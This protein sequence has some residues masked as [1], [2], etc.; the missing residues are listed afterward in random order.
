MIEGRCLRHA[1]IRL[2]LRRVGL[3]LLVAI[4]VPY[5]SLH[6]AIADVRPFVAIVFWIEAITVQGEALLPNVEGPCVLLLKMPIEAIG[7]DIISTGWAL[8]DSDWPHSRQS[9][10]GTSNRHCAWF[11][12]AGRCLAVATATGL[13]NRGRRTTKWL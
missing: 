10:Q 9:A 12:V 6:A 5:D 8:V 2:T 13:G 3:L 4:V 11:D 7:V 1:T